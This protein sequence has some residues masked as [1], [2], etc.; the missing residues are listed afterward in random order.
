MTD[1]TFYITTFF[2]SSE[3]NNVRC[4]IDMEIFI[5]TYKITTELLPSALS[6]MIIAFLLNLKFLRYAI[7]KMPLYCLYFLMFRNGIRG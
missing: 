5:L 6:L 1:A 2:S 7:P 3:E 4:S